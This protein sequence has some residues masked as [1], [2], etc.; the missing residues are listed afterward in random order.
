[1]VTIKNMQ[2]NFE[3]YIMN[4][5]K[6][7]TMGTKCEWVQNFKCSWDKKKTS[8]TTSINYQER[9][10]INNRY[11]NT[12]KNIHVAKEKDRLYIFVTLQWDDCHSND[13]KWNQEHQWKWIEW[14]G[15]TA[16]IGIQE[17]K[18]HLS[19]NIKDVIKKIFPLIKQRKIGG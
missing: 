9:L 13:Q 18:I 6:N 12:L 7:N 19:V 8:L 1:M 17:K 4:L 2:L 3:Y 10:G 16:D 11:I 14:L 15:G 5:A